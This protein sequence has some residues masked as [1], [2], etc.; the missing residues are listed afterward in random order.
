MF[1]RRRG[2]TAIALLTCGISSTSVDAQTVAGLVPHRAVYNLELA[3]SSERSGINAMFGRM[4][5]EFSGS[6][7]E[8]YRIN[9]RF[10]TQ[11]DAGGDKKTTDQRSST[12]EDPASGR[13]EFDTKTY[14]GEELE[15]EVSGFATRRDDKISV[16]IEQPSSRKVDVA[17]ARF[18][19]QHTLDVINLARKG[20]HYYEAK[21]YDGSD[22]ADKTLYTTTVVGPPVADS[23]ADPDIANAQELKNQNPWPVTIAY[24]NDDKGTDVT[25]NYRMS[26]KLYPN[27]VSRDLTMDYGDFVLK[28]TLVKLDFL[29]ETASCK[30]N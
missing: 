18:P 12:F 7:C 8:G 28:G 11:L 29:P 16:Q 30:S 26:F 23:G 19:T 10:V 17:I 13:F 25:P 21:I 3:D 22:D 9:F 24:F 1:L 20:V 5:Y 2:F 14:N 27:G 4:V 6:E 15:K